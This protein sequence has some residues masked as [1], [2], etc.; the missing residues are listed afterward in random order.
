MPQASDFTYTKINGVWSYLCIIMDLF[1]RKIASWSISNKGDCDFIMSIL[2][3]IATL[4]NHI[5][6]KSYN[7]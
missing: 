4:D 7:S 1:S 3:K 5:I 2:R 6:I